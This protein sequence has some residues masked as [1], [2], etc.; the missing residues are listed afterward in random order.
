[1]SRRSENSR[2][3]WDTLLIVAVAALAVTFGQAQ[4]AL[5]DEE[6]VEE[7]IVEIA[8]DSGGVNIEEQAVEANEQEAPAAPAYWLGIEGG[9]L[10]SPILRTH[11]QLADDVGVVVRQIVPGSPAEKAG[12]KQHDI[13]IAVGG[14]QITDMGTLQK[15]V[16]DSHSKPLDLKVLRLAKE[17]TISITPEKRPK[18]L[19]MNLNRGGGAGGANFNL[20]G[21]PMGELGDVLKK[22]QGAGIDGNVGGGVRVFGPGMVFKGRHMENA[23]LPGGVAVTVTREGDGPAKVTVK[24]GDETWTVEGNDQKALD[25]LPEDVRPFVQQMLQ[26]SAFGAN[27]FGANAFQ[28]QFRVEADAA[29]PFA[30]FDF[31]AVGPQG[32]RIGERIL[33]RLEKLEHQFDRLQKE[34]QGENL[35]DGTNNADDP[36]K[37]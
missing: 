7:R 15:A 28:Q 29:D 1:M 5:A 18:D 2:S 33:D 19:A 12:L 10:D 16:A 13:L 37:T 34:F 22:L 4:Q 30:N 24:K 11:L 17:L 8:P 9:P 31:E 6:A 32:D 21:L 20:N 25:K 35:H 23:Q 3:V 27:P 14:E 36:S 26:G